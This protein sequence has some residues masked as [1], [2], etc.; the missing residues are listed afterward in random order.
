MPPRFFAPVQGSV[1]LPC[2]VQ[3]FD[4]SSFVKMSHK[5]SEIDFSGWNTTMLV[6]ME[7]P[8]FFILTIPPQEFFF[9]QSSPS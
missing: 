6:D 1:I 5:V 4:K 9:P 8:M 2:E 3:N 7:N